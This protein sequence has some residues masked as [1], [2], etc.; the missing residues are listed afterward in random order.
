MIFTD[1][2]PKGIRIREL[3]T[4]TK[5]GKTK[6]VSF[7]RATSKETLHYLDVHLTN[8]SPYAVILHVGVNDL[9][10]EIENL[11]KHLRSMVDKCHTCGV[12]YVFILGLVYPTR[13]GSPV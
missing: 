9:L 5:N 13:I 8:S 4:F 3:N 11:E 1:S 2:I 10:E 12:K 7:S 6:M